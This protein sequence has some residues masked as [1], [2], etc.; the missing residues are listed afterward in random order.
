MFNAGK[1]EDS[2]TWQYAVTITLKPQVRR[3]PC[4][5]QYD[6]YVPHII[7]QI[8]TNFPMALCTLHCEMT[9]SFD[10]HLHGT[11]SFLKKNIP[12]QV[13]NMPKWFSDKFRADKIIGYVLL[14]VVTDSAG[15]EEY[16]IKASNDFEESTGRQALLVCL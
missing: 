10:L 11:I 3:D 13:R 6:K 12:K 8:K 7:N 2:Y 4:E 15:W 5:T 14:K 1:G 16:L 9:K